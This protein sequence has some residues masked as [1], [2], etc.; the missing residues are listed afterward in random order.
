MAGEVK[1][2]I[3]MNGKFV[4]FEEA[5]IHVLSHVVHYGSSA[6]E[7]I[8]AYDTPHGTATYTTPGTY[9]LKLTVRDDHVLV[10]SGSKLSA[11]ATW[12]SVR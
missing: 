9:T 2:T 7:G 6:F 8:R 10:L 3:W 11:N 1:G 12:R 4:P 5:T